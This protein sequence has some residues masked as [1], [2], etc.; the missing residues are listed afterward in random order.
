MC[1]RQMIASVPDKKLLSNET[2]TLETAHFNAYVFTVFMQDIYEDFGIP[3]IRRKRIVFLQKNNYFYK[4]NFI[5]FN[6][7]V[8]VSGELYK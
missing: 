4:A 3:N 5:V 6:V 7:S 8:Y 2:H 1:E